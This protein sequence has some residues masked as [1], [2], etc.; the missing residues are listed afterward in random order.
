MVLF[1]QYLS[2]ASNCRIYTGSE[3]TFFVCA[4]HSLFQS[5]DVN[6]CTALDE[7]LDYYGDN[8]NMHFQLI[9]AGLY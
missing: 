4:V 5:M 6:S 1:T 7:V 8:L 3:Y 2:R 9:Y